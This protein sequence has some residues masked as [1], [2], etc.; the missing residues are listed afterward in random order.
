MD[1]NIIV[2]V[3]VDKASLQETEKKI[4]EVY[5]ITQR[6][7][8]EAKVTVDANTASSKDAVVELTKHINIL[9]GT[10]SAIAAGNFVGGPPW[11]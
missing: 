8:R 7:S 2:T 6:A 1:K 3:G 10:A 9:M 4:G 11:G 5:A